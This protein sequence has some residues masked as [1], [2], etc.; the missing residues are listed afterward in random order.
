MSGRGEPFGPALPV[1]QYSMRKA[2]T[3]IELLVVIAIIAILAAILFPVFAQAKTSAKKASAIASQ[4]Q[5]SLAFMM[6]VTDADDQFP[7]RS[8]C[9]Q[10]S[11][12]N[13][14]LKDPALNTGGFAGCTGGRFYNSMTWQTWQKYIMPYVK[15]VDMFF[16]TLRQKDQT[17]WDVNGEILNS[18]VINLGITGSSAGGFIDTPWFG[19]SQAAVPQISQTMLTGEMPNTFGVPFVEVTGA[20]T[21]PLASICYPLA[22][23]EYWRSILLTSTGGNNCTTTEALD[24]VGSGPHGGMVIGFAD[25]SARFYTTGK[26]LGLTPTNNEYLPGAAFPA[27]AFASNCRRS[28]SNWNVTVTPVTNINYPLWG[29]GN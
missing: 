15:N 10:F 25:G 23:R 22:V 29:L 5:I 21:D 8:G 27:P 28:T 20:A 4:K 18:Y 14:A 12:I 3:L 7:R 19:G 9:E 13:P 1:E 24:P 2:F 16:H 17:Q 26:F 11:S 6:Y